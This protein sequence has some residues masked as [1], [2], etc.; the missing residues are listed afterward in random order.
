MIGPGIGF[1]LIIFLSAISL[2]A[3]VHAKYPIAIIL[4]MVAFLLGGF[5]AKIYLLG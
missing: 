1:G 4:E 3:V 2:I 5:L